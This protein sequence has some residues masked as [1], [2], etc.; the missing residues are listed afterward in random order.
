MSN[1]SE[2]AGTHEAKDA[3]SA[4]RRWPLCAIKTWSAMP[5]YFFLQLQQA[6]EILSFAEVVQ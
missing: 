1:T 5:T 2:E 6:A 4:C 3:G